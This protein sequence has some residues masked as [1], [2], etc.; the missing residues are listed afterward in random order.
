MFN[1]FYDLPVFNVNHS[2]CLNPLSQNTTTSL[3]KL[4]QKPT[5]WPPLLP[6]FFF[7]LNPLN[8]T[9]DQTELSLPTHTPR[10]QIILMLSHKLGPTCKGILVR[11]SEKNKNTKGLGMG[12]DPS[13]RL[14]NVNHHFSRLVP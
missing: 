4:F 1:W 10:V 13:A 5:K 6:I 14:E 11:D 7:N 9:L 12:F 8:Y 3:G 2:G